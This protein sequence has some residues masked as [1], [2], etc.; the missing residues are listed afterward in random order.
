MAITRVSALETDGTLWTVTFGRHIIRVLKVEGDDALEPADLNE[1]GTQ[2]VAAQTPGTY[3]PGNM[4]I[5]VRNSIWR[6][7]ML[8]LF[9]KRGFGNV[10]VP[11]TVGY[12]HPDLG[13]DSDLM[14]GCRLIKIT[15]AV[16]NSNKPNEVALEW[17]VRQY[18]HGNDRK[19]LNAIGG[20]VAT[21][22]S[23]F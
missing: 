15:K 2:E 4:K 12:S 20:A 17:K 13:S 11:V 18:W 3:K 19:T 5:T 16:D 1:V 7:V 22:S 21:G 23:K 8:P 9:P 14:T 10:L 6:A